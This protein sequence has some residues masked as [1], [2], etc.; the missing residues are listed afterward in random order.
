MNEEWC[1]IVGIDG[2]E[3]SSRGRACQTSRPYRG[4]IWRYA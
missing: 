4:H 3:V 2:Y 1:Q